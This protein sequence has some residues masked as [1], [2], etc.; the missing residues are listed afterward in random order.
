MSG[1]PALDIN[2]LMEARPFSTSHSLP[3]RRWSSRSQSGSSPIM[4]AVHYDHS[5]LA[6][7]RS[8]RSTATGTVTVMVHHRDY[9]SLAPRPMKHLGSQAIHRKP[10]RLQSPALHRTYVA[11]EYIHRTDAEVRHSKNKLLRYHNSMVPVAAS[12]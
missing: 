3:S 8:K 2:K 1:R 11:L 6:G 9:H 5:K 12:K 7:Y 4:G 10:G